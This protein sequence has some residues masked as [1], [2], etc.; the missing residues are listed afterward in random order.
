MN[1]ACLTFEITSLHIVIENWHFVQW[2][3]MRLQDT[4]HIQNWPIEEKPKKS[5]EQTNQSRRALCDW[6]K[7][8]FALIA[9]YSNSIHNYYHHCCHCCSHCHHSHLRLH[10]HHHHQP[11]FHTEWTNLAIM[12]LLCRWISVDTTVLTSIWNSYGFILSISHSISLLLTKFSIFLLFFSFFCCIYH[13]FT[14]RN[15]QMVFDLVKGFRFIYIKRWRKK[16][17]NKKTEN[18]SRTTRAD[19]EWA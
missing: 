9:A 11:L 8:I 16:I 18:K 4:I 14:L 17:A 7:T 5:D 3:G 13:T 12:F 6:M 19:L 1:C 15:I 2:I 10:L